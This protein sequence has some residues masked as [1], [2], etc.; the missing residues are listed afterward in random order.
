MYPVFAVGTKFGK[1]KAF[2]L[3]SAFGAGLVL[4]VLLRRIADDCLHYSS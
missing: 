2:G 3:C 1:T 4:P